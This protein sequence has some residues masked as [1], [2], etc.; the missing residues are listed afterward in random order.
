MCVPLAL[1]VLQVAVN[2]GLEMKAMDLAVDN[3]PLASAVKAAMGSDVQPRPSKILP[4]VPDLSSVAILADDVSTLPCSV[5]S[6]LKNRAQFFTH[7]GVLQDVPAN[8]R[9]LRVSAN[10]VSFQKG[11]W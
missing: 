1:I 8:S 6:I 2:R 3:N 9:L 11:C 10:P 5:M 4:I 7:A